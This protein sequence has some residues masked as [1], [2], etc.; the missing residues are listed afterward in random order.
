MLASKKVSHLNGKSS[1]TRLHLIPD[2]IVALRLYP[3]AP[4]LPR[5]A[6]R[7]TVLPRG[8]GLDGQAPISVRRNTYLIAVTYSTHRRPSTYGTDAEA[9][10]P[11][12]WES[13][14][15]RPGWE[16]LPFGGGP[17]VCLGRHYALIQTA[18]VTVR[19]MQR[20]GGIEVRDDGQVW[21]ERIG[22]VLE[23]AHGSKV[24]LTHSVS[25]N[26]L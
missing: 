12:R 20:F 5:R 23:N 3:P 7:P 18:Y 26:G 19:L 13:S 9:F 14:E 17:R 8:G 1:I 16:F 24:G 6:H 21:K 25:S 10:R 15:L 11:Q 4:V 22:F 2:L